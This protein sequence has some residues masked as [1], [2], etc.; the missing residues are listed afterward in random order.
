MKMNSA[1]MPSSYGRWFDNGVQ[2]LL[3]GL[4]VGN[5]SRIPYFILLY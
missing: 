4:R 2:E 3:I 5:G 1:R